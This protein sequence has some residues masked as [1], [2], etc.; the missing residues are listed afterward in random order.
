[1][2][3][4]PYGFKMVDAANVLEPDPIIS[5]MATREDDV[6]RP[7]VPSDLLRPILA[8]TLAAPV[9]FEVRRAFLF[10]RNAMCY[11]FWYYPLITIGSQ[12][13]LRVADYATDV[14]ITA[15]GGKPR[16]SFRGRV[17]Q[18]VARGILDHTRLHTWEA[19]CRLRNRATHPDWQEV[20][21]IPQTVRVVETVATEILALRW[22]D[23]P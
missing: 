10:A 8:V 9:P 7:M 18:L 17:D 21:G 1:M 4:F 13:I 2:E 5:K 19:I 14:A 15:S 22:S 16:R 3:Q 6:I 12:Q 20:W 11:G 23:K